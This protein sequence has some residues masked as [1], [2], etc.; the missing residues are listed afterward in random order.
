MPPKPR[1]LH[2]SMKMKTLPFAKCVGMTC[3]SK[4]HGGV[5]QIQECTCGMLRKINV[6]EEIKEF[7]S[8]T[9]IGKINA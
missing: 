1:H 7:G 9:F 8:W 5:T 4:A 3:R 6:N 2:K